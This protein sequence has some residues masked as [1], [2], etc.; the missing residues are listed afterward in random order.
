M[1]GWSYVNAYTDSTDG[2]RTEI[3]KGTV[4]AI[5]S[6]TIT[7]GFS[8]TGAEEI[9]AQE[10]S[11]GVGASNWSVVASNTAR[12][13]ANPVNF[14]SVTA[15]QNNELYWSYMTD[16]SPAINGSSTGFSYIRTADYNN[17]AYGAGLTANTAYAPTAS[18]NT[19]TW[20]SGVAVIISDSTGN[21]LTVNGAETIAN[22]NSTTAFQIQDSSGDS[23]LTANTSTLVITIAGTTTNFGTL[24]ISNAHFESTQTTAPTIGMTTCAGSPG[25]TSGSTDAAG[26]F[27]TGTLGTGGS[28][29]ITI[30]FNKAYSIAPKSVL[31][32]PMNSAA[33]DTSASGPQPYVSSTT[34]TTF[35]VTF[36]TSVGTGS[37][38]QFYY[39]VIE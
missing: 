39:W 6:S 5:G 16:G 7:V 30:T 23:L 35:V 25:V 17:I 9:A 14:P 27:T 12:N 36:R 4:N 31:I 15:T 32:T 38:Y 11:A 29:T 24:Q 21:A 8:G 33:A 22:T 19:S 10:F 28:C 26:S 3:W 20:S 34:P 13:T 2:Y 1:T 18:Q 37:A